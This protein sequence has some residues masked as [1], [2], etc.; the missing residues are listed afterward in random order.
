MRLAIHQPCEQATIPHAH[1][2]TD[3]NHPLWPHYRPSL[4]GD[5]RLFLIHIRGGEIHC[6]RR[7][8]WRQCDDTR[9]SAIQT[10]CTS[11]NIS[12][13]P[14]SS[15]AIRL[16]TSVDYL[17]WTV[18]LSEY[19]QN[20]IKECEGSH[21]THS[22]MSHVNHLARSRTRRSIYEFPFVGGRSS[23]PMQ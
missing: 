17:G 12:V 2:C 4:D 15:Q 11:W 19:K 23:I 21:W 6:S 18:D 8:R 14:V 20:E 9:S 13:C 3:N 16:S 5:R 7:T 1:M 22:R 10:I